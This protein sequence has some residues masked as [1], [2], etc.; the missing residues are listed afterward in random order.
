MEKKNISKTYTFTCMIV[1][2]TALVTMAS[3]KKAQNRIVSSASIN[4]INAAI[5]A[6]SVKVNPGAQ[7]RF[8]WAKA[9][10]QIGYGSNLQY[11]SETGERK[12]IIVSAT[13]TTR[14]FFQR[15][16]NLKA[17][18]TL[19]LC[20][21]V[22]N[23]DTLFREER[24]LPFIDAVKVKPDSS[25]YIR[26]VNLSPN[27]TPLNVKLTTVAN[28]ETSNLA[29]KA[30]TEF[31]KYE[32]K[33]TTANYVF[34]VRDAATNTLRTTITLAPNSIRHKTISIIIRGLMGTT[35][36]TNAF[37]FSQVNYF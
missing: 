10:D 14:I 28:N 17:I 9:T 35:S 16:I 7:I 12:V 23:V 2:A 6:G 24:N 27:S 15:T 29:Y 4:V 19:Y 36:G 1:L 30:I 32:A 33:T 25:A 37:G 5:D 3:C 22:P 26:F 20:G 8:V 34:E 18:N 21:Q 11:S 31:K 13:D